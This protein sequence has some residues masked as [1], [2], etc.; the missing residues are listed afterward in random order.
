[1]AINALKRQSLALSNAFSQQT[2]SPEF[3][4][5]S[6]E[7][8]LVKEVEDFGRWWWNSDGWWSEVQ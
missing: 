6:L 1:M 4:L 2:V 7:L 8:K 3:R 5:G